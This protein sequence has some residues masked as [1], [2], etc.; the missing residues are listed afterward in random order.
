MADVDGIPVGKLAVRGVDCGRRGLNEERIG[1]PP[2]HNAC[3]DA[4]ASDLPRGRRVLVRGV[5]RAR[6]KRCKYAENMERR[7]VTLHE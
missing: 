4:I 3:D 6:Q 1:I 7:F 5:G 2:R